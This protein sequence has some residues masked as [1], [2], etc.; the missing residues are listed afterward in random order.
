MARSLLVADAFANSWGNPDPFEHVILRPARLTPINGCTR[1]FRYAWTDYAL[2]NIT[3]AFHVYQT[4]QISPA[5]INLFEPT[6]N[7]QLLS[8][9]C[10]DTKI[11][12]TLYS[13][14][15]LVLPLT[16]C[17]YRWIDKKNIFIAVEINSRI[18]AAWSELEV[19]LR[20]YQ[21]SYFK[22]TLA[23]AGDGITVGGGVMASTSDI[24]SL[25]TQISTITSANGYAGGLLCFL[26]GM[27]VANLNIANVAVGDAAE[28]IYDTSIYKVVDF[29][30]NTLPTFQSTMDNKAKLLLHYDSTSEALI[31][32]ELDNDFYMLDATTGKGVYIHKNNED[33]VRQLTHKDYAIAADYLL[34]YYVNFQNAQGF[35]NA[36]NLNIRMFVR[37]SGQPVMP[38]IEAN[39]YKFMMDMS[40]LN[41][42]QAMVGVNASFPLWQ[43]SA[44]EQS[45]F[46]QLLRAKKTQITQQLVE[47]AYGYYRINDVLG[48]SVLK[49]V[50]GNIALPPAH[51][52]TS[53]A[54]EYDSTGTLL[55]SYSVV[56][57]LIY[58]PTNGSCALVE[59]IEGAAANILDEYYG[60]NPVTLDANA[61]YRF[62]IKVQDAGL[63][64]PV[65]QDVTGTTQYSVQSG[66]AYWAANTVTNII[67]RIVR[68]DKKF[69]DYTTTLTLD[70]GVLTHQ[71]NYNKDTTRGVINSP[72]DVPLG[73]L[74]VWLNGHALVRGV[75]YILNFPTISIVNREFVA[76]AGSGPNYQSLRVRMSGFCD[77]Q[78]KLNP[79]DE[80]GYVFNGVLSADGRHELHREKV[81]HIVINGA[82]VALDDI[83][84]M[85]DGA[86]HMAT[87]SA[88][89]GKPYE[90]R[91]IINHLNGQLLSE[92][93]ALY[94][95]T[96]A[97]EQ[98]A[99]AYASAR[100]TEQP[101]YPVSPITSLYRLFS[102][103]T[104][105]ILVDLVAGYIDLTDFVLPYSDGV[106]RSLC[107]PYLYLLP[108]DP[109]GPGNLPDSR[110]TVV[111]AHPFAQ[112]VSLSTVQYAFFQAVVR[113]FTDDN[114]VYTSLVQLV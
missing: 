5:L 35:V 48:P 92:P 61:G 17:W 105:K 57:Q 84:F 9:A 67:D 98:A 24:S 54:Y 7:W 87:G 8:A 23:G 80:V 49:V 91:D 47:S 70:G 27:R 19:F 43:A 14:L 55:G 114:V 96:R 51:Q 103:F 4:G 22:S 6:R 2:P 94:R 99:I 39:Y 81:Q 34:A 45:A 3:S 12:A 86:S 25:A 109:I 15:G 40:G 46:M 111:Q 33:T 83:Y 42:V 101:A 58:Y 66:V 68:S 29:T 69:L 16:R 75:D 93:Y 44:L 53:T 106:V 13:Q 95:A 76:Y 107:A 78:L 52:S 85:E 65:W 1:I 21:N 26:N 31:D 88:I 20:L 77:S 32:F 62:Y 74:D 112:Q 79:I 10:V 56:N 28:F 18:P 97:N 102:P 110:Y 41:Q 72:L 113:I 30:I 82:L 38:K 60:A 108:L 37:Y 11:V 50:N 89:E 71:I 104:A 59:F 64:V 90:V 63:N 36:G 73:S 100:I